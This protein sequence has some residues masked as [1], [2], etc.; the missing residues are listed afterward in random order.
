M[1]AHAARRSLS[2]GLALA[3]SG[4]RVGG[5]HLS[6]AWRK[7][8]ET[9]S[10]VT[11]TNGKRG[12]IYQMARR[13]VVAGGV[14]TAANQKRDGAARMH[15][16]STYTACNGTCSSHRKYLLQARRGGRNGNHRGIAAASLTY[17]RGGV[18]LVR[19]SRHHQRASAGIACLL[20]AYPTH[21]QPF[22]AASSGARHRWPAA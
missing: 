7:R 3:V 10:S 12:G 11:S 22:S 8:V 5:K 6:C 19:R 15:I 4:E 20:L 1:L 14:A 17:P 13:H 16:K 21:H 18:A 2:S 9:S